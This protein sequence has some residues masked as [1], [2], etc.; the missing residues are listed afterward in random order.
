LTSAERLWTPLIEALYKLNAKQLNLPELNSL[1]SIHIAELIHSDPVTCALYYN[2]CTNVFRKFLHKEPSITYEVV[3]FFF[4]TE[5]QHRGSE[6]EHALIWIKNAP[7][8]KTNSTQDIE[9]FV[10]KYITTDK[11][12]LPEALQQAHTHKHSRTCR[13]KS[14]SM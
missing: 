3:D 7:N 2:H 11:A 5:F 14:H 1:D 6:H 8:F 10:D 4:V 13:K 12:L 9:K